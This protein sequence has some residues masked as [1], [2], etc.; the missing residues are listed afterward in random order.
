[1]TQKARLPRVPSDLLL[2]CGRSQADLRGTSFGL[3]ELVQDR[4]LA[5]ALG[6][7]AWA[8]PFC[9][10]LANTGGSGWDFCR[11]YFS[12]SSIQTVYMDLSTGVYFSST[13]T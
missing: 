8:T 5:S 2:I 6:A 13:T 1:M 4:L 12:S 9:P 10:F 7:R 11:D 3:Q